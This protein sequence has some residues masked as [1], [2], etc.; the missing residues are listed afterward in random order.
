[1]LMDVR[2][3]NSAAPHDARPSLD[4]ALIRAA[5]LDLAVGDEGV[6]AR[7][8]AVLDAAPSEGWEAA[9]ALAAGWKILPRI[10]PRLDEAHLAP[11][12][13]ER[14]RRANLA[15]ALSST[16]VLKR[17]VDALQLLEDASIET[18]A[19]K[20]V[21]LIASLG[22]NAGTRAT[23]DLD[24][25][26]RE[27][28][29]GRARELLRGNGFEEINPEFERHMAEIASSREL[30]N[31]ARALRKDDFEVDLHWQFGPNPPA[32]L[33]PDRLI[34]RR[35]ER[36]LFGRSVRVVDPVDAVLINVHH[37]L[38]NSFVPYCA[39]RDLCD[40][41]S[42]WEEGALAERLDELFA[43]AIESGL[44]P[45]LAALWA[46]VLQRDPEHPL[47]V[48]HARLESALGERG[49]SEAA[50][51]GRYFEEQL[52][53][54]VTARF[55]LEVFAPRVYVRSLIGALRR[56][57]HRN[58]AASSALV[59]DPPE[60]RPLLDRLARFPGRCLRVLR[61]MSRLRD[62]P[63]YRA[64]ARAKSQFH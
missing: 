5:V 4:Q 8:A 11:E 20:G 12:V 60:T 13:R 16:L 26:V 52:R 17:S 29:A 22:W 42:W 18:V 38:R 50:L 54:G 62:I 61:E 19:I 57:R 15:M 55:T 37:A 59:G 31:F 51:L 48:G 14:L 2:S 3:A 41:K 23:G 46:V 1:M 7:A 63:A 49:R 44:A 6:A 56:R 47:R 25:V 36:K 32:A 34:R 24:V 43:L 27:R 53:R 64:V 58:G 35:V 33:D 45:S 28:D 30:H 10:R 9:V 40:L 21:A 39:V